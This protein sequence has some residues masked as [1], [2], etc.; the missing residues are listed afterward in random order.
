MSTWGK[1]LKRLA[2]L[3]AAIAF[4]LVLPTAQAAAQTTTY[5]SSNDGSLNETGTSC[6]SPLIRE[7]SVGANFVVSEVAIGV[8]ATHTSRGGLSMTL[9]SPAGTRVQLVNGNLLWVDGDNF[10][11]HLSDNAAQTV[12]TDGN[13]TNHSTANPPPF[14]HN[15]APDNALSAFVGESSSGIW[16]LE[17]CNQTTQILWFSFGGSGTFR[18]AE[19]YLSRVPASY[20]DL[21]LRKSVGSGGGNNSSIQYALTV[22]NSPDSPATATGVMVADL[23]PAG[24]SYTSHSGGTYNPTTGLWNVDTLAPGQSRTLIINAAVTAAAGTT[25]SNTA[26]VSASSVPDLDSTP[27]N[28]VASEDDQD[29]ASFTVGSRLAGIAPILSCPKSTILFDW[30]S[31]SWSAG[32]TSASYAVP[33]MGNVSFAISNPGAWLTMFGGA[34]PIRT[35]Q[36]TGGHS[37]AQNSLAQTVDLANRSQVATTT[38]TLPIPVDGLQFQIFDV[39]YGANQFADRV[40]VT[41]SFGG[42]AVVPVLTNGTANYVVG[43]EAFGDVLS[44]DTESGGNL[45]VTFQSAVDTVVIEYGNHSLAPANPRQQ[46]ITLHD[47]T[48]C[49]PHANILVTKVSS[50]LSDPVRGTTN[51]VAIPG[52]LVSYCILITNDG[53]APASA[54]VANDTLP[55]TMTY[56]PG[57]LRSG[58]ACGSTP[59]IEDDNATGSDESDPVGAS[60]SGNQLTIS[61]P[62]LGGFETLAVAFNATIN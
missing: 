59:T 29:S 25:I 37:P 53:S 39:D 14:Q 55:A 15:F 20:A 57:S 49:E 16:R 51:P 5:V 1:V 56:V 50:V 61:A 27:G 30:D 47:I 22:E 3:A 31:R 42:S 35:T 44:G 41:G 52:A 8:F 33:G 10:N 21:S 2:R 9:Q 54:L 12:N 24:V 48:F 19:L 28:S 23:L 4:A 40:R 7:F 36:V 60:I 17:I 46:A 11:V 32:S 34:N 58:P 18:H 26:Q 43:N 45:T 13:G 38:I 62:S 6:S